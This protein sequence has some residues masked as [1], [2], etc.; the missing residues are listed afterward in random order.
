MKTAVCFVLP[1][2]KCE[3]GGL[4]RRMCTFHNTTLA[5][6][7][8]PSCALTSPHHRFCIPQAHPPRGKGI[9][10]RLI[11]SRKQFFVGFWISVLLKG[12]LLF[13][14][15]LIDF[16]YME[17]KNMKQSILPSIHET[18]HPFRATTCARDPSS[19]QAEHFSLFSSLATN[20]GANP[21]EA[22]SGWGKR[23]GKRKI[24]EKTPVARNSPQ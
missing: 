11:I 14:P 21:L 8:A 4:S 9:S 6:Y 10:L 15:G 7:C 12:A 13:A 16:R 18:V 2:L 24:N 22:L 20:E 1:H 5:V 19:F 3:V 17:S 23:K